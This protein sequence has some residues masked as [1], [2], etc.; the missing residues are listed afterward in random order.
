MEHQNGP[1][2]FHIYT[3]EKKVPQLQQY[4]SACPELAQ[5]A[6]AMQEMTEHKKTNPTLSAIQ[7]KLVV[8]F[9]EKENLPTTIT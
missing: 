9:K 3:S 6:S 5:M 8:H 2:Q 4:S 1:E 7:K